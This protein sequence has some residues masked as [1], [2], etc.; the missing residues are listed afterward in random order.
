MSLRSSKTNDLRI[1]LKSYDYRLLD[2]SAK[3]IVE[4]IKTNSGIFR[5]PVPLPTKKEVYTIIRSPH[6][7]KISREQFERRIHKRLIVIKQPDQQLINH[8]RRLIIPSG[9]KVDVVIG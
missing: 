5:G 9:V 2:Q 1:K 8:L 7:D 3:K 4:I 6:V